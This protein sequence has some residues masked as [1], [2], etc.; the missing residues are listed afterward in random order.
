[1]KA[2]E[3]IRM[4]HLQPLEPEGGYFCETYRS[5]EIL[6]LKGRGRRHLATAIYYLLLPRTFSAWHRLRG[7]E[8]YHFY[9]GDPV[10]L[11]LIRPGGDL[12]RH[13]LGRDLSQGQR[14]Q[15]LVPKNC[16]QAGRL[17]PG[18]RFALLGTTMAPGFDWRD[19]ELGQRQRLMRIFPQW[20][21]LIQDLTREPGR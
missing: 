21:S 3:I 18:G 7:D 20:G 6:A 14:P 12:E 19:F 10:D 11:F 2:E 4:L 15:A 13:V 9:W 5:R 8:V 17:R 1:M 16:W